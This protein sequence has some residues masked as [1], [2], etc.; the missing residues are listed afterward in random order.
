[1]DGNSVVAPKP[2]HVA[3]KEIENGVPSGLLLTHG[4]HV[5]GKRRG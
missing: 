1:M 2:V 3:L 5:Q 4:A